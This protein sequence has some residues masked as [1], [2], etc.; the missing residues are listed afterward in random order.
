MNTQLEIHDVALCAHS[1]LGLVTEITSKDGDLLYKGIHLSEEKLG[2]RWQSKTPV[3]VISGEDLLRAHQ[4][5]AVEV[6]ERV[7]NMLRKKSGTLP[8][9]S[10]A[11]RNNEDAE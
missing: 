10:K 9:F 5:G 4:Y 2:D 6:P 8:D 11:R 7:V 3:R 1:Y